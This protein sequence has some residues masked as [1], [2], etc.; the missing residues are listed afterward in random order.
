[1]KKIK[2]LLLACL[3]FSM[4]LLTGADAVAQKDYS[5]KRKAAP[6]RF[7]LKSTIGQQAQRTNVRTGKDV[8]A[9]SIQK[10]RAELQANQQKRTAQRADKQT[11]P[12]AKV[13]KKSTKATGTNTIGSNVK[14]RAIQNPQIKSQQL[15]KAKLAETRQARVAK[16]RENLRNKQK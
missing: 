6:E 5:S 15:T 13:T 7:E 8:Q 16:I 2:F 1:M 3:A 12:N 11:R 4:I 9:E 10:Q 14:Q